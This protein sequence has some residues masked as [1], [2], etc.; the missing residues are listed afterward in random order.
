MTEYILRVNLEK[1]MYVIMK[2]KQDYQ[3]WHT[4]F[5]LQCKY[6]SISRYD[7]NEPYLENDKL[8]LK[9]REREE[10]GLR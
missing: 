7:Y 5:T 4:D 1:S 6:V 2:L 10:F 9:I 8:V 3:G